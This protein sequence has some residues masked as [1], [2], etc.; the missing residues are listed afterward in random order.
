MLRFAHIEDAGVAPK[1]YKTDILSNEMPLT[2]EKEEKV[3]QY[4]TAARDKGFSL[5]A[6]EQKLRQSGYR[7]EDIRQVT[8]SFAM[9]EQGR[10]A[11]RQFL[12]MVIG[13][14]IVVGVVFTYWQLS[15]SGP[16]D[17]G[18]G[19]DCFIA[20]ANS[21]SAAVVRTNIAGS[22]VEHQTQ[23]C[24]YTRRMLTISD[25]EPAEVQQLFAN[26]SLS[27]AY[28][29][30]SFDPQLV[31]TISLGIDGCTGELKDAIDAVVQQ[32]QSIGII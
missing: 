4:I 8:K 20:A 16:K 31:S 10:H 27:C 6:I 15:V 26:K 14:A 29:K 9:P 1:L 17:C 13:I 19:T 18:T 30:G 3:R 24:T 25:A 7:E 11:N 32:E 22:I 23:D 12:F 28:Q 5:S 21:C 2:P